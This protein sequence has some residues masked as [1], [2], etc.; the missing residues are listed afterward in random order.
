[1]GLRRNSVRTRIALA[2]LAASL[3]ASALLFGLNAMQR[4]DSARDEV[5]QAVEQRRA[6]VRTAMEEEKRLAAAL[7]GA[8]AS[9]PQVAAALLAA[10]RAALEAQVKPVQ[11]LL[12]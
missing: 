9:T 10:D 1:M 8:L 2:I 3:G 7:A 11:A 12:V 4:A 5:A 6:A